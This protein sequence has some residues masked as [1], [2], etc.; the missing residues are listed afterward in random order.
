MPYFHLKFQFVNLY[1]HIISVE[2][3]PFNEIHSVTIFYLCTIPSPP[4]HSPYARTPIGG[5][6][7]LRDRK[8]LIVTLQ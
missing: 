8:R 3:Q 7:S 1:T 6:V 4:F 5:Q 2:N